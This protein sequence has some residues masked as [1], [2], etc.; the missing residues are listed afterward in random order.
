M[1]A[2]L[3][4][5]NS[6][7]D[8]AVLKYMNNNVFEAELELLVIKREILSDEKLSYLAAKIDY[9][10]ARIAI[11][12]D[13]SEYVTYQ[14]S[15]AFQKLRNARR[16]YSE[17]APLFTRDTWLGD[18]IN[19]YRNIAMDRVNLAKQEKLI[20]LKII[21]GKKEI[22]DFQQSSYEFYYGND[23][24]YAI[25]LKGVERDNIALL[26]MEDKSKYVYHDHMMSPTFGQ[27]LKFN[28][29]G[30]YE[31]KFSPARQTMYNIFL[32][33]I[34]LISIGMVYVQ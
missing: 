24:S 20:N 31:L 17:Y 32:S 29:G 25:S 15:Y 22:L 5:I 11:A 10:L 6:K 33:S 4:D 34:I 14:Q 2:L 21:K 8:A 19:I 9:W 30:E 1:G 3:T 28:K 27:P 13:D 16:I 23:Y 7:I 18:S 12:L 26:N